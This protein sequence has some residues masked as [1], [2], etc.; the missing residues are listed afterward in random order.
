MYVSIFRCYLNNIY[1]ICAL[2][3]QMML[4]SSFRIP[5]L[6]VVFAEGIIWCDVYF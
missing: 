4:N 6:L 5:V 2:Y 3:Y 1:L